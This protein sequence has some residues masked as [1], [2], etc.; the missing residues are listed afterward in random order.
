MS[1]GRISRTTSRY[2]TPKMRAGRYPQ[3]LR[4]RRGRGLPPSLLPGITRRRKSRNLAPWLIG[5]AGAFG[6]MTVLLAIVFALG[7]FA[8]AGGQ[9]LMRIDATVAGAS[10]RE[11]EEAYLPL[12]AS[13]ARLQAEAEGREPVYP[14]DL[15]RTRPAIADASAVAWTAS[16]DSGS[17]GSREVRERSHTS[18]IDRR[19]PRRPTRSSPRNAG[20]SRTRASTSG[21]SS[22]TPAAPPR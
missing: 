2:P 12:L 9:V 21:G 13:V 20:R 14:A 5:I 15:A 8:W 1:Q 6:V 22:P 10:F 16:G 4:A 7:L 3:A 18:G 11:Q 17:H 19:P